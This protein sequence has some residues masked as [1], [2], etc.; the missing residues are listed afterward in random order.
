MSIPIGCT[1]GGWFDSDK[2]T[3]ID[4]IRKLTTSRH[5]PQYTNILHKNLS[6]KRQLIINFDSY[7]DGDRGWKS[8]SILRNL[9]ETT[10]NETRNVGALYGLTNAQV[11]QLVTFTFDNEADEIYSIEAY[12]YWA[13]IFIDQVKGRF[14]IGLGNFNG[15]RDNY[16]EYICAN[17][18]GFKYLDIH[19][20]KDFESINKVNT[21]TD[22]LQKI[23]SKYNKELRVTEAFPVTSDL[24]TQSG[25][26]L[27]LYQLNAA[28]KYNAKA[29]CCFIRYDRGGEYNKLA[30][31]VGSRV[32]PNWNEFKNI[33]EINKPNIELIKEQ[34]EMILPTTR[35]GSKGYLTE[36]VEELLQIAGYEIEVV[37]G[38]FTQND[39]TELKRFQSDIKDKYSNIVVDG[40]CGRKGYFY[41][42]NELDDSLLKTE[43]FMK[44]NIFAS[45]IK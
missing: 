25:Y 6:L 41:L 5:E 1:C 26:N 15:L 23:A 35:L 37:D 43:Y 18:T 42:I 13:R 4:E 7:N 44:L 45:P 19:M 36:L 2:A 22:I 40:S 27:L 39:V 24:W 3:Y 33:I 21:N 29:F 14:D 12:S 34:S 10:I 28:I 11:G 30:F 20:Q 9:I 38:N 16:Y 17:V 31:L 8:E 32:H